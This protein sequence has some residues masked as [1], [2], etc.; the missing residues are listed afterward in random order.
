MVFIKKLKSSKA[1]WLIWIEYDKKYKYKLNIKIKLA[2][3]VI[4]YS[5][6]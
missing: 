4:Y 1:K 6:N 5:I 2:Q 3:S